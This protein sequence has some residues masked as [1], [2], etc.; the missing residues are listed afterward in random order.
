MFCFLLF[1]ELLGAQIGELLV[2]SLEVLLAFGVFLGGMG[3]QLGGFL[4]RYVGLFPRFLCRLY[5]DGY[6]ARL[7]LYPSH[8][9]N[10]LGLL[11]GVLLVSSIPRCA[12]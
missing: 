11:V 6:W 7:R 12:P 3:K 4:F 1:L 10:F 2:D 8:F 9:G 5:A